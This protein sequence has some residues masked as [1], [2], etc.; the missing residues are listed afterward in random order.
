MK[1]TSII[2]IIL[3]VVLITAGTVI[4]VAA[5]KM[6][7]TNNVKLFYQELDEEGNGIVQNDIEPENINTISIEIKNANV[8]LTTGGEKTTVRL[9]N[10]S[11]NAYNYSV[12][13]KNLIIDDSF[14]ILSI[15]NILTSGFEFDGLRNYINYDRYKNREK[16]VEINLADKSDIKKFEIIL[17]NGNIDISGINYQADYVLSTKTGDITLDQ[18]VSIS[19]MDIKIGK[20]D[21]NFITPATNG[22]IDVKIEEGN[23]NSSIRISNYRSYKLIAKEGLIDFFGDKKNLNYEVEPIAPTTFLNVEI[24]KGNINLEALINSSNEST[25]N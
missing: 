5:Q 17:E 2:F 4:C 8:V 12:T 16:L 6:A 25:I 13:G 10:F 24:Y 18:I 7:E 19:N 23:F 20:G 1:P 22:T 21:F 14:N 3:A 11:K 15:F 9:V